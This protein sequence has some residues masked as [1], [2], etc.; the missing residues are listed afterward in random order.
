MRMEEMI[1]IRHLYKSFG[2]QEV[3]RDINFTLHR[4]QN[5]V[6]MGKSGIGKSVLTKCIVG[7]LHHDSGLVEIFGKDISM[8]KK[9]ELDEIR[10]KIGYLFQGGALYDSMTVRENLEFPIL[11]SRFFKMSRKEINERVE[12]ALESVGLLETLDKMPAELSGGMKKRV[13]LARTI[14]L[15]PE[16][17]LYDEPTT[18]LD[19]VTSS[20]ISHLM[21]RIQEKYKTSSIIIT[22][23]LKCAKLT[24]NTI[25]LLKDGNFYAEGS[26]HDLKQSADKEVYD[27]FK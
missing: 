26:Y 25:K 24:G 17:I 22:H 13:G 4:G 7:L 16:I 1:K 14:I 18:G 11:R 9:L 3:L 21:L 19:P 15:K 10:L 8:L 20:E 27:Y 6:I 5:I 12:E 23:D 2:S